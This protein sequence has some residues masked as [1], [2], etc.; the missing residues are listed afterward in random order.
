[1]DY[2]LWCKIP[3]EYYSYGEF[4]NYI[5]KWEKIGY[6]VVYTNLISKY[7][8]ISRSTCYKYINI[9]VH[10]FVKHSSSNINKDSG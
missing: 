10:L 9:F 6:R 4:L 5:I 7:G 8:H 1:M 2:T 3:L